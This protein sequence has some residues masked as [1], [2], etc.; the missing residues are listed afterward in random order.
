M[1]SIWYFVALILLVIGGLIFLTG[2]YHLFSP[3]EIETVLFEIHPNIWW[4]F[5]MII[6]GSIMYFKTRNRIA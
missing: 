6:F 2:I 4:G 3:P 5:L 1:K